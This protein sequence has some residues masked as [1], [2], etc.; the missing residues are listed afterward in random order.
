MSCSC[1]LFERNWLIGYRRSDHLWVHTFMLL[2]SAGVQSILKALEGSLPNCAMPFSCPDG[3]IAMPWT[4]QSMICGFCVLQ[5]RSSSLT[6]FQLRCS[7]PCMLPFKNDSSSAPLNDV[8]MPGTGMIEEL[9]A[10]NSKPGPHPP[11]HQQVPHNRVG[12]GIHG[13]RT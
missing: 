3:A 2:H 1:R 8:D 5:H 7:I 12:S 4:A 6:A 11:L 13:C 10:G 9:P